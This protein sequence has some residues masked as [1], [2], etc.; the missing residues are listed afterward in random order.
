MYPA[1]LA[2]ACQEAGKEAGFKVEV[3]DEKKLKSEGYFLLAISG[4]HH[5][6]VEKIA[7]FYGFDDFL[8]TEYERT[9]KAYTG[10][11]FTPSTDKESALL[12]LVKKHGLSLVDSIAIGDSLSDAPM[13][14][15]AEN[16][17]AFNPDK[18]LFDHAKS[19]GWK[20]VIERKNVVYELEYNNGTYG[21]K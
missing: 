6:L 13:L 7:N 5:E 18:N 19:K 20:I 17:I 16:P 10:K 14:A 1:L 15:L 3:W 8:G 21:L 9:D 2:K 11:K 12:G 4:S